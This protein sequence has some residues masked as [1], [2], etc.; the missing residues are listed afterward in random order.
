MRGLLYDD[1]MVSLVIKAHDSALSRIRQRW[2]NQPDNR[3]HYR[4]AATYSGD[5]TMTPPRLIKRLGITAV[6]LL[7]V[8]AAEAGQLII[9]VAAN[10]TGASRD[11]VQRFE[12]LSGHRVKVSYGSTGKLFA[13]IDN[14]APF[15]LLLAADRAHPL[16]AVQQGLAQ[17]DSRFTYARGQLVL[18][19]A[20]PN[21]FSDGEHYLNTADFSRAAIANPKTAPYGLA[22]KQVLIRL[23]L[24]H[25]LQQRL[26]RG[27]SIAQTFQF[28]ATG[29]AQLGFVASAQLRAWPGQPG[30]LWQVPQS[31]YPP[32][33]QQAVLLNKG[34]SNPVALQFLNFLKG[35]EARRII[36]R[37]G[38]SVPPRDH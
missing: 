29:N 24:W 16:R 23:G 21:L 37:H 28:T 35:S 2:L 26:V 1:D 17:G 4:D 31:Y 19:S 8:S 3:F 13:Q 12:R 34:R 30:S 25:R 14:G 15:E 9:A 11:L 10:F 27:D 22:A 6:L 36:R 32:I 5:H 33:E 7:A 20:E 18:W 38:Y